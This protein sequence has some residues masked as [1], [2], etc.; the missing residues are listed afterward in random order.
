M[1]IVGQWKNPAVRRCYG[2]AKFPNIATAEKVAQRDSERTGD[3]IIAYQCF[4][5]LRFHVGLADRSQIL[6]RQEPEARLIELPTACPRC[7]GPIPEQRRIAAAEAGNA[8]VFCSNRCRDKQSKSKRHARRAA[9][10]EWR[11]G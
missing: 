1:P 10:L 5:C 3:L 8:N 9:Q 2:K 7:S 4:D 6:A 11:E